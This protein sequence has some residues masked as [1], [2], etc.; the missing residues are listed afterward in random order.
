MICRLVYSK[1]SRY[2]IAFTPNHS[3]LIN[4]TC[5]CSFIGISVPLS[6][7]ILIRNRVAVPISGHQCVTLAFF[8][9]FHFNSIVR[10]YFNIS[11]FVHL[12]WVHLVCLIVF[13]YILH[14]FL[15]HTITWANNCNWQKKSNILTLFY[16]LLSLFSIF[17]LFAVHILMAHKMDCIAQH[18]KTMCAKMSICLRKNKSH[19]TN[20]EHT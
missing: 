6:L 8:F 20:C 18:K 11:N 5:S 12:I 16:R 17:A 13:V 7:A 15:L 19:T 2:S 3:P 10:S 14:A 9:S 1:H 4:H